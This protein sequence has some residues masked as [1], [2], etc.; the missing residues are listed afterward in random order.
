MVNNKLRIS[1][2]SY[3]TLDEDLH[4]SREIE[5]LKALGERGHITSLVG[6][7]SKRYFKTKD[8]RLKLIS[9]PIRSAPLISHM[10]YTAFLFLF[11]P[12]HIKMEKPDLVIMDPTISVIGSIP[13]VLFSRFLKT[14]FVLDIKSTPVEVIGFSS[15][16]ADFW[17]NI[18]VTIAKMM[19]SGIAIV[20]PM[21]KEEVCRKFNINEKCVTVWTN[22]VPTNLFDPQTCGVESTK[23]KQQLGLSDKFVILYHGVFSP[24]RGL[25][26]SIEAMEI[27]NQKYPQITLLLLGK[28][29]NLKD[30]I[31]QRKLQNNVILHDPV[32]FEEVPK[33][34]GLTDLGLVPLPDNTSWRFQNPLN[35]LEYLAMEKVVLATD[36]PANRIVMNDEKCCIYLHSVNPVEIASSIENAYVN[37]D[38]L[39]AWGKSGRKIIE[40]NYTWDKIAEEVE[41][42]FSR[43]ISANYSQG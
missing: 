39:N 30:L 2:V 32:G 18:S 37:K 10:I 43:I 16:L 3:L 17:F 12:I 13:S 20:T 28:G 23:L 15:K 6:V 26:E 21:M 1:W 14:H 5:I 27:V 35:L 41:R 19:F 8:K 34:I 22:G 40:K 42:Y 7:I 31:Q 38:K 33:F 9:V 36:I 29:I 24:T 4:K 25:S 11:L